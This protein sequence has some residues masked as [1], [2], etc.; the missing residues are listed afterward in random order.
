VPRKGPPPNPDADDI[1]VSGGYYGGYY[2]WGWSGIGFG[3]YYG[4]YYDPWY[5]GGY[6][7]YS[8]SYNAYDGMLRLKMKPREAQVLVDGYFMGVVDDF[9]GM[10]QRLHVEPGPHRVEVR[11]EGYETLLFEVNI[12]PDKTITYSGE[13]KPVTP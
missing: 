1:Y 4:G 2:P 3:G 11:L 6:P 8:G 13:L 9:D 5:Y 7:P 12:Q 10:W